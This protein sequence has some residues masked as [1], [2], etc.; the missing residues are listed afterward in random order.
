MSNKISILIL[1]RKKEKKRKGALILCPFL[2]KK[3]SLFCQLKLLYAHL[4][5]SPIHLK[6][7]KFS[8]QIFL[9]RLH[10]GVHK[11]MEMN[12]MKWN[13]LNVCKQKEMNG[14]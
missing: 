14:K 12:K 13:V 9:L 4:E 11:R 5:V 8:Q 6:L 3:N 7:S 10:L 1:L 2:L